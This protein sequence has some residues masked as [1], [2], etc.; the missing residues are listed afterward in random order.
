MSAD[1]VPITPEAELDA[2]QRKYADVLKPPPADADKRFANLR[3]RAALAGVELYAIDDDAG[4][5]L[6]VGVKW[7]MCRHMH[8]LD[9][10]AEWIGR[11]DGKSE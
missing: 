1:V 11:I 7:A 8:S 3:S 5:P 2:L 4:K 10:V 6:F 9:E